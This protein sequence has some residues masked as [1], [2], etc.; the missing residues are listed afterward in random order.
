M[1]QNTK[2]KKQVA[3]KKATKQQVTWAAGMPFGVINYIILMA[4]LVVLAIGWILLSGGGT[5]NPNEFTGD[6]LF[7]TRRLLVAP[8]VLAIGFTI[9]FVAIFLK[10]KPKSE[11]ETEYQQ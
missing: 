11:A 9:E 2:N 6:T 1:A 4:G 10:I 5:D 3:A 7:G 8:I